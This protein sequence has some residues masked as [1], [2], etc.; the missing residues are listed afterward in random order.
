MPDVIEGKL[1]FQ[2]PAGWHLSKFDDST[3]YRD[4]IKSTVKSMDILAT[5]GSHHWW[6]EVKDC[7][8]FERDNRPRLSPSEP[9]EVN[10]VRQWVTSQGYQD[11]VAI[12]R[13]KPFIVDELAEKVEGTL[14]SLAAAQRQGVGHTKAAQI[15]PLA[16]VFSPSNQWQI[17]LLLTWEPVDFKRLAA[18]LR[19]K[20]KQRLKVHN[21]H[22]YVL[23]ESELA[24]QQPW[25]LKR[26]P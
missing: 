11:K 23:N 1:K 13:K 2:F 20:L 22:C 16:E 24:P 14:Y 15:L 18:K 8:S 9:S 10:L 25:T 26:L 5:S 4:E 6:I 7:A 19:D 12:S 21:V 17:V 3:W